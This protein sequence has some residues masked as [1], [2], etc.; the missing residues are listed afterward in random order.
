MSNDNRSSDRMSADERRAGISL[1]LLF[2]LRMLGLFLILPVFALYGATL[3]GGSESQIGLALGIYG[4]VQACLHIPLGSLSDRIGR[5]K[6]IVF[7]F[8]L[9]AFGALVA[10]LST[11]IVGV[12]IG[13][14][15]QGAG[16]VSAVITAL[17][18]DLSRP[19]QRSKLMA[20]IGSSIGLCF[21]LSLVAAPLLASVIG[22]PG[23][24]ELMAAL[25]LLAPFIL[26]R[27]TPVEP[28]RQRE[29]PLPLRTL[30]ADRRLLQLQLGVFVLHA[31]QMALWVMVPHWLIERAHW[32]AA[33]HWQVYL[34]ALTLSFAVMVPVIVR[35]EK[36]GRQ[37]RVMRSAIGLLFVVIVAMAFAPT[38]L[39]TSGL[40][41]TLFFVAFNLLE[42]L[43]PSLLSRLAPISSRGRVMGIY[44]TL[45]SLGLFCGGALGGLV[46][47]YFGDKQVCLLLAVAV[48]AWG[49]A[50]LSTSALPVNS[51]D[52]PGDAVTS[53]HR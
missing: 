3:P 46:L 49:L 19:E 24:F 10:A 43:Q 40:L 4:L 27:V 7:G 6:V 42:A 29:Q 2:S 44:N 26:Y 18:A 5:K 17:I 47:Q 32:P 37:A 31:V 50:S 41:L 12:I 14:A 23:I 1:A 25:A 9:F 51:Q 22:V 30:L 53:G 21:A 38:G 34:L 16:A 35:G 8:M 11:H 13:R 39:W 15:I 52:S 20:M 33:S 28:P 36:N 45:Q 48:A